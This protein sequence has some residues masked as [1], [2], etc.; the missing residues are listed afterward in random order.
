[1]RPSRTLA[2]AALALVLVAAATPT[3]GIVYGDEDDG[4]F[5]NIGAL[6]VDLRTIPEEFAEDVI[7]VWC[8]GT[9][10]APRI[11]LT[12]GHCTDGLLLDG[13]VDES[14]YPVPGADGE[15]NTWVSFDGRPSW[16]NPPA[17]AVK[18][19]SCLAIEKV[20]TH[21]NYGANMALPQV[22]DIGAVILKE[23]II[24]DSYPTLAP[25]DTL[26][27]LQNGNL[28]AGNT[29]LLRGSGSRDLSNNGD[30]RA[31]FTV[32]GYG[33]SFQDPHP[34]DL[35][36]RDI[37]QVV[38]TRFQNLRD[39][40]LQTSQNTNNG[41][42]GGSC[43]GDSGGPIFLGD[44]ANRELVAMTSWGDTNCASMGDNLRM[45]IERAHDFVNT[46]V[47]EWGA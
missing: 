18:C 44:G 43:S 16:F 38:T 30:N 36:Y 37:R 4:S 42:E 10:I 2:L 14:G 34:W 20:I 7:G 23:P 17:D 45:D 31:A 19:D 28:G 6:M 5:P 21:P 3:H 11:F 40:W 24:K 13:V 9:L 35:V 46:L 12:A 39:V 27:S 25:L 26:A 47:A 15:A 32:V 1:M 29:R 33:S 8:T 22:Y 41:A